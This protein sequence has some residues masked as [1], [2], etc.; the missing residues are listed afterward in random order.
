[1]ST[2]KVL[3]GVL[4]GVATGAILGILLAPDKGS[5]TRRKISS[6][7]KGYTD[8]LKDK[9]NEFKEIVTE[10]F[11][12]VKEEV[13]GFTEQVKDKSEEVKKDLNTARN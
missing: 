13:S 1:M 6:K 5:D 2:G 7:G 8:S 10:K 11:D 3:L 12:K 9:F 4:A